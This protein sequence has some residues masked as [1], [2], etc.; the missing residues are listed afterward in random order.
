MGGIRYNNDNRINH[1]VSMSK[2]NVPS[3][4]KE[5][6]P[7]IFVKGSVLLIS[8]ER[9]I[10]F[11]KSLTQM[12]EII[13]GCCT[14]SYADADKRYIVQNLSIDLTLEDFILWLDM[15]PEANW[16]FIEDFIKNVAQI[17][18]FVSFDLNNP[19]TQTAIAIAIAMEATNLT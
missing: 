15:T 1:T 18:D 6:L 14:W 13:V 5:F 9:A 16:P 4:I 3:L 12:G 19:K 8:S 2:Q 17:V 7:F 11:A 10:E